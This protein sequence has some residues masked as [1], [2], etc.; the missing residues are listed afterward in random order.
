MTSHAQRDSAEDMKIPY[1]ALTL[2]EAVYLL[3]HQFEG[4]FD[5]GTESVVLTE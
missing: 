4:Y 5:A 3:T 2:K 1:R